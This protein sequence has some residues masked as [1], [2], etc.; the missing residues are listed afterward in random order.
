MIQFVFV[1][2]IFCIYFDLPYSETR[3]RYPDPGTDSQ[4]THPN[5]C[6][7]PAARCPFPLTLLSLPDFHFPQTAFVPLSL[8]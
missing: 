2:P 1:V 8:P 3:T 7:N 5:L 4:K 6:W